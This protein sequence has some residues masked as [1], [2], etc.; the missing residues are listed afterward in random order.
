MA[1]KISRHHPHQIHKSYLNLSDP[2]IGLAFLL[3]VARE[4]FLDRGSETGMPKRKGLCQIWTASFVPEYSVLKKKESSPNFDC[5]LNSSQGGTG[6][7][8]GPKYFQCPPTFRAY[9]FC[10]SKVAFSETFRVL[11]HCYQY[12]TGN[13]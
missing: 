2:I 9:A 10:K 6:R 13:P 11:L 7:P 8:G 1:S 5:I 12:S 4:L 3:S